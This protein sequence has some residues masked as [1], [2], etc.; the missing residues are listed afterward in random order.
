[1]NRYHNT[2]SFDGGFSRYPYLR[3]AKPILHITPSLW[4]EK[5]KPI[6]CSDLKELLTR[7]VDLLELFDSGYN[8]AKKNK[9]FLDALFTTL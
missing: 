7:N 3:T 9:P 5:E 8:D 4:T 6:R 2:F 1:V